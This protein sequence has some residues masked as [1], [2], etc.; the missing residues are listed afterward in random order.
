MVLRRDRL[1]AWVIV[2]F[3]FAVALSSIHGAPGEQVEEARVVR[4]R[5]TAKY[6]GEIHSLIRDGSISEVHPGDLVDW[7]VRALY[8]DHKEPL[9]DALDKRLAKA[10]DLDEAGRRLLFQEALLPLDRI[11]ELKAEALADQVMGAVLARFD[12]WARYN[13]SDCTC[14]LRRSN[15]YGIGVELVQDARTGWARVVTPI[16]DGPAYKAG[17]R[18]DDLITHVALPSNDPD[19]PPETQPTAGVPVDLLL[20]NFRGKEET[21]IGLTVRRPGSARPVEVTVVRG[22]VSAEWLFGRQRL[23]DDSWSFWLEEKSK[24]GYIRLPDFGPSSGLLLDEFTTVLRNL[25]KEGLRGLVLDLRFNEGGALWETNEVANL[26][27]AKG[28]FVTFRTRGKKE[29]SRSCEEKGYLTGVPLVVLINGE[30]AN[31]TE[32]LAACFQDH[33]RAMIVGERSR[34]RCSVHDVAPIG[35]RE[36]V[37]TIAVAVRPSG[38]KLDRIAIPGYDDSWGVT[39]DA[40][41]ILILHPEE[42][43]AL[44]KHL[45]SQSILRHKDQ[46]APED[47]FTDR[48]LELARRCLRD[49]LEK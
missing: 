41:Q 24:I 20:A 36:M 1:P 34:G 22:P 27:L 29:L 49:Q 35:G 9:P 32:A 14:S 13:P 28:N 42:R 17:L 11:R 3:A 25:K 23:A 12:P 10:R 16:R 33:K 7:T 40:G 19:M 37:Q 48:Q 26:F 43:T 18:S 15:R 21:S 47:R 31:S 45:V 6:F 46:P 38:K 2:V 4:A 5:K 39:P 44:Q 30:S 8:Q